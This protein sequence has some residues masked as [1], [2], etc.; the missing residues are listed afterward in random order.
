MSFFRPAIITLGLFLLATRPAIGQ[1]LERTFYI[2]DSASGVAYPNLLAYNPANRC[3][4]VG[5]DASPGLVAINC[6]THRSIA[7]IPVGTLSCAPACNVAANEVYCSDDMGVFYVIDGAT[8]EVIHQEDIGYAALSLIYCPESDKLVW[9]EETEPAAVIILD[10][11]TR[12]VR[13]RVFIADVVMCA[14]YNPTTQRLYCSTWCGDDEEV[15]VIDVAGDS[16]I[17]HFGFG[18]TCGVDAICTDAVRNRIY[19]GTDMGAAVLDGT[20]DSLLSVIQMFEDEYITVMRHDPVLNK[21]YCGTDEGN[22]IIVDCGRSQVMTI[23]PVA[24]DVVDVCLNPDQNKVYCI[25]DCERLLTIIDGSDNSWIT[26]FPAGEEPT[27]LCYSPADGQVYCALDKACDLVLIDGVRDTIS[28]TIP[29]GRIIVDLCYNYQNDRLYTANSYAGDV[30]II[31]GANGRVRTTLDV[32]GYS[33]DELRYTPTSNKVYSYA[34][35]R[36]SVID[37]TRDTLLATIKLHGHC[38]PLLCWNEHQ[39][40][41]YCAAESGIGRIDCATDRYLGKITVG[42]GSVRALSYCAEYERLHCLWARDTSRL[43]VIDA[44]ADSV[45]STTPVGKFGAHLCHNTVDHRLYMAGFPSHDIIV[46]DCASGQVIDTISDAWPEALCYNPAH[47]KLYVQFSG[48]PWP[49]PGESLM[50]IDCATNRVITRLGLGQAQLMFYNP[51]SDKLYWAEEDGTIT[52]VSGT[53]DRVLK[54]IAT[55]EHPSAITLDPNRNIVYVASYRS[56]ISVIRDETPNCAI[57]SPTGST[58]LRRNAAGRRRMTLRP[59]MNDISQVPA[60]VYFVLREGDA[61][62]HKA[63]LLK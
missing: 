50:V 1:W 2:P 55:P 15:A 43:V 61:S 59:G 34:D 56:C 38:R 12:R 63:V 30:C 19:L 45:L 3:L 10:A 48:G 57:N 24:F 58:I 21:L 49:G 4:Y 44:T 20:N 60:G 42:R 35:D 46:A 37:G 39:N 16:L 36:L 5:S 17:G 25:D 54:T 41:L 8:N 27:A 62:P 52:I 6:E 22:L 51:A 33:S 14:G 28:M 18:D 53:T 29:T 13:K 23:W 40:R 11:A 47:N 32:V 31:D 9:A 26:T 7:R